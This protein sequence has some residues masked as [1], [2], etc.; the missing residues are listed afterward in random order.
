MRNI[1]LIIL[2][3]LISSC[4]SKDDINGIW[5][6]PYRNNPF[7]N[8]ATVSEPYII[9]LKNGEFQAEGL[10]FNNDSGKYSY[11]I[12][13]FEFNNEG[14]M[15]FASQP[16]ADSIAFKGTKED[17][18][19]IIFRKVPDSLKN[20]RF[21]K[22]KLSGKKFT[23]DGIKNS[24]TLHFE[25]DS[26]LSYSSQKNGTYYKRI[27]FNEF[28]VIFISDSRTPPLFIKEKVG[29]KIKITSYPK[30]LKNIVLN[31]I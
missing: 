14:S 15:E 24:D 6:G 22:I 12:K 17:P 3:I 30:K 28:D 1:L 21:N 23:F 31:E 26:I 11:S 7:Q 8:Q 16:N 13:N 18:Y 25:N 2:L 19:P 9:N 4:E 20:N 10:H 29:K 5:V 27:Y